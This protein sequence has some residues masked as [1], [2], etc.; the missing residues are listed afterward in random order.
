MPTL[1]SALLSGPVLL[2]TNVILNALAGRG[3]SELKALLDNLP[4][5]FVSGPVIAELSWAKGRL[6]PAH[7]STSGVLAVYDG[8][9]GRIDPLKV[10]TPGPS[11]WAEAGELAGRAARAV[12]GASKSK[13]GPDARVELLNDAVTAVVAM[14]AAAT[15][16]TAD[17]DFDVLQQMSPKLRVVFY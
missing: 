9:I 16:V 10:L 8:V 7:P 12:S 5:A 17:R 1:G 14:R 4:D 13:L 15:V 3:P 2:D 11:E 6:D